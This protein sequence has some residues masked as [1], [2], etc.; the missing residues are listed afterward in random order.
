MKPLD[1]ADWEDFVVGRHPAFLDVMRRSE[2]S[3]GAEGG[4]SLETLLASSRRRPRAPRKAK[5]KG[6]AG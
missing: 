1:A 5:A 6:R 3:Y 2:A 4:V